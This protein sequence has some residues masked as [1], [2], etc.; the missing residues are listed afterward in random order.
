MDGL[1]WRSARKWSLEERIGRIADAGFDGVAVSFTDPVSSSRVC[2]LATDRGLRVIAM[3]FPSTVAELRPV[4]ERAGD[5]GLGVVDHVNM[6][7]DVRPLTVAECVPLLEGWQALAD[8]AKVPLLVETHRDRMTCDLLFTVQLLAA[9][10]WLRLTAD[11]SHFVVGRELRW[12]IDATSGELIGR[13]LGRSDAFH[14]RVASREQVQI[15]IGFPQHAV[16]LE[17]FTV[18]WSAGF[19]QYRSTHPAD[20]T[21]TFTVEL[22]PPQW[23]ALT[24]RDGEELSDRWL[25]AL[26]LAALARRLWSAL[27]SEDPMTAGGSSGL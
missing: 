24:G 4:L 22:G 1:P 21:L 20:A 15:Q 23:Y 3:A 16:W 9:V 2:Q 19:R 12:P 18:W 14:G 26:Q 6:Q 27:E 11:L 10:P 8:D 13:V 17:L 5:L 25:E 7:P